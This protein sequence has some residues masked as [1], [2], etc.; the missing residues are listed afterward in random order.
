MSEKQTSLK[1]FISCAMSAC[2]NVVLGSIITFANLPFLYLD[3]LGTIFISTNFKMRYG[4]FTAICTHLLLAA[5]HGPLALPFILVSIIIAIITNLC[6]KNGLNYRKAFFTGILL[7]FIGSL[8]SAPIR[9]ILYGGFK[10]LSNSITDIVVFSLKASGLKI[11]I[12]AYWGAV[13]DGIIDKIIS[14]SLV[15]WLIR[16]PQL[17]KRLKTF[18]E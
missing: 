12:A 3:S 13:T 18:H 16:L 8:A 10:G 6:S 1:I 14:C 4:I 7:A 2:I 15:V 11:L 9:V 5:I 17:Q